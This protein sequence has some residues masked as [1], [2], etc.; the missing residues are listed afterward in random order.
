MLTGPS[1]DTPTMY[2]A[3]RLLSVGC[4]ALVVSSFAIFADRQLADAS[5]HEQTQLTSH[6]TSGSA[7]L[8]GTRPRGQPGR[9]IDGAAAKLTSPF[10]ALIQTD[11]AWVQRGTETLLG[12]AV[13]GLG[14]G[15]LGRYSRA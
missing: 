10:R 14:L 8:S 6:A 4:C 7:A 3:L 13:Y 15:Y 11:N 12:L 5:R 1:T 2:R 9:F